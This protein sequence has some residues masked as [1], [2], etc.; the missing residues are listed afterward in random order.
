M[1]CAGP[2]LIFNPFSGFVFFVGNK[3]ETHMRL[4]PLFSYSYYKHY[5]KLL[6]KGNSI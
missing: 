2:L 3:L 4:E 1:G 6:H 5:Q